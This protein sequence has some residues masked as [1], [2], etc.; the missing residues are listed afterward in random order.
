[1]T[2]GCCFLNMPDLSSAQLQEK[3]GA[4]KFS[5]GFASAL[6]NKGGDGADGLNASQLPMPV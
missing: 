6:K 2:R 1:M 5:G 4:G 3:R